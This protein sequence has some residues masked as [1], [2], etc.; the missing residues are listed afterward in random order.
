M[1]LHTLAELA[2]Y[3]GSALGVAMVVPQIVRTYRF[4]SMA[5]VSAMSWALTALSCCTWL[6]YGVRTGELPQIPGNVLLVGG[7]VVV[8]LAVPSAATPTAR[9]ARLAAGGLALALAAAVL[10]AVVLG[11]IGFA[12]GVV[13]GLPQLARSLRR[14]SA[15]SAVSPLTWALRVASQA[16]WLSYALVLHDVVVAVSASVLVTS[17]L[18]VLAAETL[19]PPVPEPATSVAVLAG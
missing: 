18:V 6:L 5:G 17:A 3:L 14:S 8:V 11:L 19:R 10:P 2:G 13:S 16:C 1:A 4:R 15:V 12:L 7:A 9:A